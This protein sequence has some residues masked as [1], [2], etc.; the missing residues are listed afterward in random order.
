MIDDSS[1]TTMDLLLT[2]CLGASY[3]VAKKFG[4]FE[5]FAIN[6]HEIVCGSKYI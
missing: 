2:G 5:G 6:A 3:H 1:T 4:S